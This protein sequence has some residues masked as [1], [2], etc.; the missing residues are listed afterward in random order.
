MMKRGAQ[1]LTR[2]PSVKKMPLLDRWSRLRCVEQRRVC[3]LAEEVCEET[4]KR[5]DIALS[6]VV[7]APR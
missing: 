1:D 3:W 5:K 6:G 7:R 4:A 2:R